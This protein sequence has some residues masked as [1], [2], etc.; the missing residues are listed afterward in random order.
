M[1]LLLFTSSSNNNNNKTNSYDC[2]DVMDLTKAEIE[3]REQAMYAL[4]AIKH[5][6]PGFE[7]A[8]VLNN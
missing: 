7:K 6:L 2:T 3:G 1:C 4:T 8:K 5:V